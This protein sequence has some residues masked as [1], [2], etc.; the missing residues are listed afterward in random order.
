MAAKR[1][2]TLVATVLLAVEGAFSQNT[3]LP[4]G[5]SPEISDTGSCNASELRSAPS[6]TFAQ[7]SC[8]HLQRILSRS[9]AIRSAAFSAISAARSS[10]DRDS[11]FAGFR[12]RYET[13]YARRAAQ[14]FGEW[15]AGSLHRE[16]PRYR[17]SLERGFWKRSRFA[18]QSVL[19]ARDLD[20]NGRVAIAPL[21]GAFSS[22]MVGLAC[23]TSRDSVADGLRRSGFAYGSYYGT[24]ILREFRPELVAFARKFVHR[25]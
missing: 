4:S 2:C 3:V 24:A 22:G 12:D 10:D 11:G 6:L 23:C 21:A 1:V 17:P 14:N 9:F 8:F 25:H 18:L 7:R 5:N 19:I 15:M 20:G 16:D 13:Y